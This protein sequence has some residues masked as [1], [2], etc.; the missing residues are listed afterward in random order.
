[1]R[2]VPFAIK[3]GISTAIGFGIARD[4]HMKAMYDPDLYRVAIKYRTY[5]D[6]E[7]EKGFSEPLNGEYGF[8]NE[9]HQESDSNSIYSKMS[10][11]FQHP[12]GYSYAANAE[13]H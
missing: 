10:Q 13:P 12:D 11:E 6:S 8:D 2:N 3:F 7:F 9:M 5:Y 4:V 1:M